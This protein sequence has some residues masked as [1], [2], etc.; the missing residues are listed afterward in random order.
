MPMF[1]G[2]SVTIG[3]RLAEVECLDF[4]RMT[5]NINKVVFVYVVNA[6]ISFLQVF[7]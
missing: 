4:P 7:P 1:A 6:E 5:F 3:V 2:V